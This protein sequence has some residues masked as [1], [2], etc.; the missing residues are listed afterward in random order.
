[1]PRKK[2]EKKQTKELTE[3][4]AIRIND[5]QAGY[6]FYSNFE[7]VWGEGLLSDHLTIEIAGEAF[8]PP[9]II[10][11]KIRVSIC[12]RREYDT[13]IITP[14]KSDQQPRAIGYISGRGP[15]CN[16]T[17]FLPF[18]SLP[19]IIQILHAKKCQG[20]ILGGTKFNYG[21]G[22]IHS[23]SFVGEEEFQEGY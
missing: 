9:K 20:L 14:D 10:G 1:M 7:K 5:W 16:F 3:S 21:Q 11:K 6:S 18:Q 15:Q 13:Q 19:A 22:K 12:A 2:N 8:S 4:Y 17:F 23:V